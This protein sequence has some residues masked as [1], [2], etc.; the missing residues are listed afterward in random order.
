MAERRPDRALGPEHDDFWAWCARGELR[1][2]ACKACGGLTWPAARAC[3]HCGDEALEWVRMSGRG[4]IVSWCTFDY[5]YYRG[6]LPLPYDAILVEL[7]EG[8][9]FVSNP[10][11]FTSRDI[12]FGAPVRV[13]FR[14]CEDAAGEFQLPVFE[15]DTARESARRSDP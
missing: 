12:T 7:E 3:E 15:A 4:R 8:P 14:T 5:D 11:G 6:L 2:Q 9:L 10:V 13:A 1:L